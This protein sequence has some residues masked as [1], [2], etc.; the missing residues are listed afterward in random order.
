MAVVICPWCQSE[1]MQE[2]GQEPEK[3][4]PVCDN[5]LDGYR[6]LKLNIGEDDEEEEEEE[7]ED[8][9]GDNNPIIISIDDDEDLSWVDEEED[10]LA[11][12]NDD[13]QQFEETVEQLL[14]EQELVPECPICREYM[15]ES[16]EQLVSADHFRPRTSDAIAGREI[17]EA[18]F[19]LTMYI[20]PSCFSV[21]SVLG[22]SHRHQ[23]VRRLS[24]ETAEGSER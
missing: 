3:F 7:E 19:T 5:E 23:V 1:I 21:Q 13:L 6:T 14:N 8:E 11:E 17:I 20:C 10:A 9:A 4:C 15:I 24:Q 16:G 12:P 18:P 22:D 2:E